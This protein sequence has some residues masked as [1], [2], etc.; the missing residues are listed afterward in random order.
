MVVFRE[1]DLLALML[2]RH[3]AVLDWARQFPP[4][5]KATEDKSPRLDLD[6]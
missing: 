3:Y 5:L 2:N 4:S 6:L 1:N